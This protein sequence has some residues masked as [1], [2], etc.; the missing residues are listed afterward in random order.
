MNNQYV[1]TLA[2]DEKMQI[3]SI[4]VLLIA[5]KLWL[6]IHGLYIT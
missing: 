1:S 3:R 5:G 6:S 2:K 4:L